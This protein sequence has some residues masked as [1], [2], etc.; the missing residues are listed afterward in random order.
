M[1]VWGLANILFVFN[2]VI[3]SKKGTG[4][5]LLENQRRQRCLQHGTETPMT[6]THLLIHPQSIHTIFLST[7]YGSNIAVG[8]R[9][10]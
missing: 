9:N 4:L 5:S 10:T 3:Y 7:Y 1:N 6:M 2:I 8:S